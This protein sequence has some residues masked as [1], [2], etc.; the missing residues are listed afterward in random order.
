MSFSSNQESTAII[1]A[2][3]MA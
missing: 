1:L 2:S 3:E